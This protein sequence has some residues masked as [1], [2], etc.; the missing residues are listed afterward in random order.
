MRTNRSIAKHPRNQ[1]TGSVR[2]K[3]GLK[4]DTGPAMGSAAAD[5][6]SEGVHHMTARGNERKPIFRNA[7]RT[8][9]NRGESLAP[10]LHG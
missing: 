7:R 3:S 2:W 1:A 8:G 9:G 4:Q 5:H 10:I 6:V